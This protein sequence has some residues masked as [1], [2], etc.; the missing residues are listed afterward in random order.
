MNSVIA[1]EEADQQVE[2]RK[3]KISPDVSYQSVVTPQIRTCPLTAAV[4]R[5]GL[6]ATLV[7][8][9]NLGEQKSI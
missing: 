9:L 7:G 3:R 8:L 5:L 2:H 4:S 1:P 6:I